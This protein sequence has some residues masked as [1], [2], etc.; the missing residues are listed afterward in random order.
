MVENVISWVRDEQSVF[1]FF[2]IGSEIVVIFIKHVIIN[3]A[4]GKK[5]VYLK[6]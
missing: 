3:I 4:G 5:S 2:V 6:R 1:F